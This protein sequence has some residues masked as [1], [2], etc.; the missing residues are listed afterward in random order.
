LNDG[1]QP[2]LPQSEIKNQKSKIFKFA[3]Q[4]I[5]TEKMRMS[6]GR[7]I[8]RLFFCWFMLVM[9]AAGTLP[10]QTVTS[11]TLIQDVLYHADGTPAQGTLLIS[12]PAFTTAGGQAIA[13]GSLSASLAADGSVSISL[14]PNAGSTPQGTYYTVVLELSD[15]RSTEYWVVPQTAQTT[16][17]PLRSKLMPRAQAVQYVGRDYVDS[18]IA[19]A[20][21]GAV[22]LSGD[23]QISGVKTF[24]SPPASPTPQQSTDVANKGYVD[25]GLGGKVSASAKNQPGGYV[26]VNADGTVGI[27]DAGK[28]PL[29]ASAVSGNLASFDAS[30]YLVDSGKKPADFAAANAAT[31]VNGQ[32][33]ALSSSCTVYD[34]TKVPASTTVNGHALSG[35]ISL[36]ASDISLG[37]VTNDAQTKAAIVPNTTPATGQIYVGN[38]GGTAFGVVSLSGDGTLAASGALT[39]TKTNGVAFAPSAT[40]DT[41][42]AANISSGNLSVSRL[43]SG[44]N[45][46][47]STYWRGDGT[48]A[49]PAGA[50]NVSG[51]GSSVDGDLAAFSG[52]S[53][54]VIQDSGLS[55][56]SLNGFRNRLINAGGQ[57]IDQRNAGAAQTITA[58]AALAYAIDRWYAYSTGANVTGQRI[59]GSGAVRYR[60]QFTGASGVTGIGFGQRIEAANSFDLASQTATLSVELANSLLTSVAWTAYY[61]S[62]TDSFGTLASPTRTQIATGTWTISSTIARYS[63]Q[64]NIPAAVTTG[65]EVVFSVGAQTSGTW[66]IGNA[67]LELGAQATPW[68]RRSLPVELVLCQRYFYKTFPQ[69]TAV[70][71]SAGWAGAVIYYAQVSGTTSGWS[72]EARFAVPMRAT[73]TITFYN[74]A[75][76]GI[77][78]KWR[79]YTQ[80]ADSASATTNAAVGSIGDISLSIGNPQVAG[81]ATGNIIGIQFTASAEL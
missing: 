4:G 37:N 25:A 32:A 81:D 17:A 49:T 35:N 80:S 68:E 65:I 78:F 8:G 74:P 75:A 55:M 5:R 11:K 51:P 62:T 28:E 64:L 57:G 56:A 45:A 16:I 19:N 72:Q 27:S 14:F 30:R 67:Q 79:N 15:G 61:A 7:P 12:W 43:N 29:P 24:Q 39:I 22:S 60:Y 41:T 13:A 31:T 76:G 1:K 44:T 54:T 71:N 18:A 38:S 50:G 59:A 6:A 36:T 20:F 42:N 69:T 46:S 52:A 33:C 58:G 73:P 47:S 70:A 63:A 3:R 26:G 40:T 34:S 2:A 48:W 21:A 23:Q 9:I 10:A 66:T 77:S 53:G